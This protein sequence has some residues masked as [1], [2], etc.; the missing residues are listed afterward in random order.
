MSDEKIT[1]NGV[2]VMLL[3]NANGKHKKS[4]LF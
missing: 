4:V 1:I 3:K 2:D